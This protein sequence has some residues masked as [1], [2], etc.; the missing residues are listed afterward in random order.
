MDTN[1]TLTPK[2]TLNPDSIV[3]SKFYHY[4]NGISI[5]PGIVLIKIGEYWIYTLSVYKNARKVYYLESD[6]LE[7]FKTLLNET[8]DNYTHTA[9]PVK[10]YTPIKEVI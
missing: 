1:D 4:D 3:F 2:D 6:N 5:Y 9:N 10:K 8:L 7:A